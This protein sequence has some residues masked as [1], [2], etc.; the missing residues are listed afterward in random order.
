MM[1]AL[2]HAASA[3]LRAGRLSSEQV[4]SALIGSVLGAV[5]AGAS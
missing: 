2:I 1:L 4:E 3:E 5:S